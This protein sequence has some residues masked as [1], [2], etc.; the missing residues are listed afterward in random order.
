MSGIVL[1]QL[2]VHAQHPDAQA[3]RAPGSSVEIRVEAQREIRV[4]RCATSGRT[5]RR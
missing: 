1:A 4:G 2:G 3:H 5:P